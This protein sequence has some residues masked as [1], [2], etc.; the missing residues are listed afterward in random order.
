MQLLMYS[1][2]KFVDNWLTKLSLDVRLSV[3][4][5]NSTAFYKVKGKIYGWSQGQDIWV[6][7]RARYMGEVKGKIYGWSQGH[8][9]WVRSRARY[10]GEVKGKI[11]GWNQGQDIWVKSRARYMGEVKGKIYGWSQGQDIWVRSRARYKW[12]RKKFLAQFVTKYRLDFIEKYKASMS[13][14]KFWTAEDW[15]LQKNIK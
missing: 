13:N 4:A 11:Y 7:S 9:I 6:K 14:H 3:S 1:N 2:S 10:M 15:I 5:S 12:S 8:D